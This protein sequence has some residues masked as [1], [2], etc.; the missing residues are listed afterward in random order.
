MLAPPV[1]V[2]Q[3]VW[4]NQFKSVPVRLTPG[5]KELS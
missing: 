1:R 3:A 5:P 2:A 4:M